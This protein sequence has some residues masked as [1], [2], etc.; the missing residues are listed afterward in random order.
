MHPAADGGW[1]AKHISNHDCWR[2]FETPQPRNV[3]FVVYRTIPNF[4][5]LSLKLSPV[6]STTHSMNPGVSIRSCMYTQANIFRSGQV[7]S[8]QFSSVQFSS[9]QFRSVQVRSVQVRSVQFSSVQVSSVQFR[10]GQVSSG[11][12]SSVQVRSV[13]FRSG[14]FS[15]GQFSSVVFVPF[16]Y[17]LVPSFWEYLCI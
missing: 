7:R 4:H 5:R 8:V 13:Q 17:F 15:S 3:S 11:Q 2:H 14:Q 9:V 12:V 16:V 6:R 1:D 10:S